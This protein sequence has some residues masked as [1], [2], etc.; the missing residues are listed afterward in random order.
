[1]DSTVRLSNAMEKRNSVVSQMVKSK[2]TVT[3]GEYLDNPA[4]YEDLKD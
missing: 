3:T 1:M 2:F 4:H